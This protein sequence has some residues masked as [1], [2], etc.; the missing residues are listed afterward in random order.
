MVFGDNVHWA[1]ALSIYL[2]LL[3]PPTSAHRRGDIVQTEERTKFLEVSDWA[4]V[5]APQSP[6]FGV[7]RT[8]KLFT[9]DP[10][11]KNT[12]QEQLKT[13]TYKLQ[14]SFDKRRLETPW[15]IVS[16]GAGNYLRSITFTFHYSGEDIKELDW[17]TEY[18]TDYPQYI[19]LTYQW[20][21]FGEEDIDMAIGGLF[22]GSFM[23]AAFLLLFILFDWQVNLNYYKS[24]YG[25]PQDIPQKEQ[26]PAVPNQEQTTSSYDSNYSFPVAQQEYSLATSFELPS[27]P[28]QDSQHKYD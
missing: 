23:V 16:D 18:T 28:Y 24:L 9:I 14:F 11:S 6:R 21:Y 20:R 2:L 25:I 27:N 13:V 3:L 5:I 26:A 17:S 19:S 1:I 4:G 8:V 15:L 7:R 10:D 22:I 12:L